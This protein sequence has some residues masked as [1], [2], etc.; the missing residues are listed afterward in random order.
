[1][2]QPILGYRRD[3]EGQ[4]VAVLGCGHTRHLRHEPP[5]Q[6]R[7]WVLTPEGRESRLGA[8]LECADCPG[9]GRRREPGDAGASR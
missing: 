7:E 1:M 4:W 9:S 6:V 8:L 2:Q 3:D 5:W